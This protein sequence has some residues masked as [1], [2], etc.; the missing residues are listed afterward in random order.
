MNETFVNRKKDIAFVLEQLKGMAD[1]S[2]I[3][4]IKGGSGIGKSAFAQKVMDEQYSRESIKVHVEDVG[5]RLADGKMIEKVALE[6]NHAA[7]KSDQIRSFEY[8]FN[9]SEGGLLKKRTANLVKNAFTDAIPV[10]GKALGVSTDLISKSGSF[11][12]DLLFNSGITELILILSSYIEYVLTNAPLIVNIE[13]IQ[14]IDYTSLDLLGQLIEKIKPTLFLLEYT[15]NSTIKINEERLSQSLKTD[16]AIVQTLELQ[17]LSFEDYLQIITS[18][19]IDR[20]NLDAI[21]RYTYVK[22]NGDLRNLTDTQVL[23]GVDERVNDIISAIESDTYNPQRFN[24]NSLQENDKFLLTAIVAHNGTAD[25]GQLLEIVLSVNISHLLI[26][27]DL[28]IERLTDQQLIEKKETNV[29]IKHDSISKEILSGKDYVRFLFVANKIWGDY[30]DDLLLRADFGKYTR[31][32]ILF[33]LFRARLYY[34]PEKCLDILKEV[35]AYVVNAI[36]PDTIIGFL[37][38]LETDLAESLKSNVTDVYYQFA[39]IYYEAGLFDKAFRLINNIDDDSERKKI[40]QA[41]LLNRLDQHQEAITFIEKTLRKGVSKR[42][43]LC[44]KLFLLISNRSLSNMKRCE[45]IFDDIERDNQNRSYL[46]YGFFL[47]NS[48]IILPLQ[49]SIIAAR[50]SVTFFEEKKLHVQVAHSKITLAMLC[51]WQA[52]LDEANILLSEAEQLLF[53]KT[54]ERHIIFNNKAA[55]ALYQGNFDETCE[56]WLQQA[57]MTALTPFD[58]LSIYIN[59][60]ILY[61]KTLRID[62]CDAVINNILKIVESEPDL[63]MKRLCFYHIAWCYKNY[64]P[65]LFLYYQVMAQDIHHKMDANDDYQRYWGTRLFDRNNPFEDYNFLL[66][67]DYEPCFLS[68]WHFEI[69]DVN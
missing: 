3:L 52:S 8:F 20:K 46:E 24:I 44:L 69:P 62:R 28:A 7:R 58:K 40:Y 39:S 67:F 51:A 25:I 16:K 15:T 12:A 14:I 17:K 37:E 59:M 63:I 26:D 5:T 56:K 60:L 36:R 57:R 38:S 27:V 43:E 49:P 41:A 21:L 13:N 10:F 33:Y 65:E 11:N 9:N 19:G 45:Q 32:H 2:K 53:G 68:Y 6:L 30:Y 66:Q 42:S 18:K 34:A 23:L 29:S 55:I 61:T 35:K 31:E 48:E 1:H 54:M 4:L 22:Y 50:E 64:N 47:R